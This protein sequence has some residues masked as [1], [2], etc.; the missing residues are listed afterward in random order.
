MIRLTLLIILTVSLVACKTDKEQSKPKGKESHTHSAEKKEVIESSSYEASKD[1]VLAPAEFSNSGFDE[2]KKYELLIETRI[3]N[4]NYSDTINDGSAPCSAK[5]FRFFTY[6]DKRPLENAFMLQVKAGVNNYPYRRLLIFTRERG[7]LVL[8]NGIT[9]YLVSKIKRPNGI[10]DLIVGIIDDL[11]NNV[12][13]RYDVFLRY[14][15]G[16]YH[17]I[18][19]IGDL[20]GEFKSESLKERATKEIKQRIEEKQLIF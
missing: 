3:C 15:D 12:F 8:M 16:K 1:T 18:E 5:F 20:Q 6:N 2:A 9:G 13:D 4:P 17:V 19:A 11:G 14:K 10:D 7:K